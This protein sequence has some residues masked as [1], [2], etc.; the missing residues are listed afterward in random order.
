MTE[1]KKYFSEIV[2]EVKTSKIIGVFASTLVLTNKGSFSYMQDEP[3]Y[4]MFDNGKC[5]IVDYVF[6][7]ELKAEYR[8]MTNEEQEEYNEREIKDCFNRCTD[9]CDDNDKVIGVERSALPYG[10]LIDIE[11]EPVDG[12][13][14]VW[15]DGDII[16]V[17]STEETF[18]SL[19]FKMDNGKSF[20]ICAGSAEADGYSY[21]WSNDAIE[22]EDDA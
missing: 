20:L 10:C 9:I 2:E 5:L 8:A 19:E 14:T 4:I 15:S 21:L 1:A 11:L 3:I 16:E 17:E 7:D 13:Y 12:K 22:S 18:A 6:I